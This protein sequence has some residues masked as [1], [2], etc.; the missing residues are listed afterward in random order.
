MIGV[1]PSATIPCARAMRSITSGSS[2]DWIRLWSRVFSSCSSCCF[3]FAAVVA[4]KV[5]TKSIAG[6]RYE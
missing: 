3:A 4:A 5:L 6:L 1:S 2:A